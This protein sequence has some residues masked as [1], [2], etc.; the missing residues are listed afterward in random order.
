MLPMTKGPHTLKK[1]A[2]KTPVGVFVA[3]TVIIFFCTLSAA[4]SIGFV[5]YYIDGSNPHIEMTPEM[6]DMTLSDLPQLGDLIVDDTT[7]RPAPVVV[8]TAYPTRI[9]IS[10]VGIDLPV[11]NPRTTDLAQLDAL[12]ASG[13]ARYSPSMKLGEEGTVVIFAHSSHRAVVHNQMYR[14]FNNIPEAKPGD[15]IT[16]TGSNGKDYIYEVVSVARDD[17]NN[18]TKFALKGDG[19]KLILFTCDTLTAKSAR[20]VLT[21]SFIGTN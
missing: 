12:L 21:A 4:T 20:Y 9:V 16:L 2:K 15:V 14:A 3:T 8:E 19:T 5:P 11:Q 13:P 10:S 18:G 1:R 6:E 17:V 7:P